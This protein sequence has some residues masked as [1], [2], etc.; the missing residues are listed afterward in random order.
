M[1]L[2]E[3][4]EAGSAIESFSMS[5]EGCMSVASPTVSV[6]TVTPGTLHGSS[7]VVTVQGVGVTALQAGPSPKPLTAVTLYWTD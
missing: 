2:P 6:S 5:C 3:P 4:S 7:G 1:I